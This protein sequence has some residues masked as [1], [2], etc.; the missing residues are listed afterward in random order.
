MKSAHQQTPISATMEPN[1]FGL[2]PMAQLFSKNHCKH[3]NIE[4][5]DCNYMFYSMLMRLQS[6]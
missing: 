2:F 4:K 5:K 6:V 3:V 1:F